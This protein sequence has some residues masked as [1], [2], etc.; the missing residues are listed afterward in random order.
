MAH[1]SN[2]Q[3]NIG[4]PAIVW[5]VACFLRI[6]WMIVYCQSEYYRNYLGQI[7]SCSQDGFIAHLQRLTM[8]SPFASDAPMCPDKGPIILPYPNSSRAY[9]VYLID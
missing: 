8:R 9:A 3:A 7:S 2:C 1:N 5:E 6:S 4:D